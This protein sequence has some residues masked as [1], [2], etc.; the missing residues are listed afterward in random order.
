MLD[1]QQMQISLSAQPVGVNASDMFHEH[2][3]NVLAWDSHT[4]GIFSAKLMQSRLRR[5]NRKI[6]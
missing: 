1:M 5:N 2:L 3:S 6:I 4:M